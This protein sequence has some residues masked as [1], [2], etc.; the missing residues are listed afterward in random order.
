[1]GS[2]N[3]SITDDAQC[4]DGDAGK[5]GNT[6][7]VCAQGTSSPIDANNWKCS[8][9]V[10][11][12]VWDDVVCT[13]DPINGLCGALHGDCIEGTPVII[14]ANQWTCQGLFSGSNASCVLDVDGQCDT[15]INGCIK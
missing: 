15:I 4:T 3:A 10:P 11:G 13:N 7:G 9:N 8:G 12:S 2:D 1:L 14:N 6:F 5:C